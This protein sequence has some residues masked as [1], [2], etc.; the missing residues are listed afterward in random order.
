MPAPATDAAP[1]RDVYT[2]SRL[3]REARAL[4]EGGFAILWIEG[5]VSNLNRHRSGHWY[6][7]LKDG[8]AR[9]KCTMW[10]NRNMLL[11]F[12]PQDGQQVV[13]RARVSLYEAGGDYQLQVESLEDAGTGALQ[14]AFEEL[15]ARLAAEGLF[16]A[17]R[18]KPLPTTPA[19]V[20][21][22]TSSGSAALRDILHVLRARFP[23]AGVIVYPV[24]VQGEAAAPAIASMLDLANA[25]AEVDVLILAR[26]GGSLEDLWAFND[27]RV[28]R[29]LARSVLP[30]VAGVGHETD[31]TISD[32]IADLRA[33]TPTAA[34]QAVVPDRHEWLR[35]FA[36]LAQRFTNAMRRQ[37]GQDRARV[38][39]LAGRLQRSHPG[40]ALAQRTQRLDE[41]DQRLRQALE[42]R[43]MR[44]ADRLA[45]L[46][47]RLP[48]AAQSAL[49]AARAQMEP[50]LR[51][52][53]AV[54]PLATLERGYAIVRGPGGEVLRSTATLSE[55]DAI[56]AQ[57][58]AGTFAAR[59]TALKR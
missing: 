4:L 42:R 38:D 27:E 41:L 55:G 36:Q 25:R 20:G 45:P 15:R 19:R 59:V 43:L 21:V 50:L 40:A 37:L 47:R 57:L 16:D 7:S 53:N 12:E 8:G 5:E 54:S 33:P 48:A 14:R 49:A 18:K 35:R 44:A 52:L 24:P 46:Q 9:I 39:S 56:E 10:R 2:V 11:R 26:G 32:F 23:A 3:N 34:A 6:F 31:V 17:A 13:A 1:G 22:I 51:A 58:G 29:A 30:V 28:A